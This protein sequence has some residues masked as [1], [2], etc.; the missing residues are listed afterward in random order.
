MAHNLF[1]ERFL[2]R[3]VPAW[4][5]LGTV[6]TEDITA[7]D[8]VTQARLDYGISKVPALA[9]VGPNEFVAVPET[10][11]LMRQPT[12]D[13]PQWVPFGTVGADYDVLQNSQIAQIVDILVAG[14]GWRLETVGALGK[15]ET[16]FFAV[17]AGDAEIAG[18]PIKQYFLM[19]DK[20]DGGSALQLVATPVR[21][22][23]QN[24]LS[25][26]LRG[27]NTSVKLRHQLGLFAETAWR[28]ETIKQA[29]ESGRSVVDALSD[30]A[31]IEV[32][33][34]QFDELLDQLLPRVAPSK[35]V[36]LAGSAN[37]Q[38]AL[39]AKR[40]QY[41]HQRKT[42]VRA[43]AKETMRLGFERLND[44]F[45]QIA[46]TGWAAFNAV[47]EFTDHA[48]RARTD[49]VRDRSTLFGDGLQLRTKAYELIRSVK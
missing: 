22:V 3:D 27:Q 25:L 8:A 10:F 6:V 42:E 26:A 31:K 21:V 45:P 33:V 38:L 15:G 40:A 30:L 44:Q 28:V 49:E 35:S 34:E 20:R 46:G 18:E 7:E 19:T 47:T 1:G 36:E 9:M 24:T 2:S 29:K 5:N 14:A 23:C 4:H 37:E 48:A 17:D 16:I 32:S 43:E 39:R 12:D 13:D 11:H 41:H